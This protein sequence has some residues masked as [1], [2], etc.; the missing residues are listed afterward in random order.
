MMTA[1]DALG[2]S[3]VIDYQKSHWTSNVERYF[4]E[5]ST[6]S[7]QWYGKLADHFGLH[8]TVDGTHFERLA[9]GQHPHTGEQ[10]VRHRQYKSKNPES[11]EHRAAW[12]IQFAPPKSVS[13]TAL[14]AGD[15]RVREAHRKA[16]LVAL[17]AVEEYVQ[18]WCHGSVRKTTGNMVAALF[19]HDTSRPVNGYPAPQLHTHVVMMNMTQDVAEGKIRALETWELFRVQSYGTAIYRAELV[20]ELQKLGYKIERTKDGAFE[21]CGYTKEYLEAAS[22]R[23]QLVKATKEALGLTNSARAGKIIALATREAKVEMAP[24]V[25]RSLVRAQASEFGGQPDQVKSLAEMEQ[26]SY[27]SP[28]EERRNDLAHYG[29]THAKKRTLERIAVFD[30]YEILRDSLILNLGKTTLAD[31]RKAFAERL[32]APQQEFTEVFHHRQTAPG[33]RYT[34]PETERMEAEVLERIRTG[35]D[36]VMPV[37][38]EVSLKDHPDLQDNKK[39]QTVLER[40]LMTTDQFVA[41]QGSAGTKKSSSLIILKPYIENAGYEMVAYAPTGGATNELAVRGITSDTLQMLLATTQSTGIDP[42]TKPRYYIIDETSLADTEQVHQFMKLVRPGV[43]HVLFMGDDSFKRKVGQHKSVGAGRIFREMQEGGIKT[44]ELNKMYRQKTTVMQYVAAHTRDGK[45]E[46]ALKIMDRHGM[47]QEYANPDERFRAIAADF[48]SSPDR[49]FIA[50]ADNEVR[51]I[52]NLYTRE[53]QR[54]AGHLHAKDQYTGEILVQ[55]DTRKED[56]LHASYYTVGDVLRYPKRNKTVG[57]EPRDYADVVA[58]DRD[59]KTITVKRRSDGQTVTYEPRLAQGVQVYSKEQRSFAVGERIQFTDPIKDQNHRIANRD[60]GT[61]LKLDKHGN[62]RVRM[63]KDGGCRK[64]NFRK[65]QHLEYSYCMTSYALQGK[66]LA[67]LLFHVD[68]D[69]TRCRKLLG[70]D[71]TYTCATRGEVLFRIYCNLKDELPHVL[72]RECVKP[73]ALSPERVRSYRQEHEL[74]MTA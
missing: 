52:L 64:V 8:G 24:E 73:V 29:I 44:A 25:F 61:I 65:T 21:I 37:C 11:V 13:V 63:D 68:T 45:I 34:T 7:G 10:L 3:Q 28:S 36:S 12:D 66:T 54:E 20:F 62:A 33:H 32:A 27:I 57:V 60:T 69:D 41:V 38:R 59:A 55:R 26:R 1:S 48:A 39:R 58:V 22:P 70:A 72:S 47:I 43:D 5:E 74:S 2:A 40:I 19:E 16:T 35:R 15:D 46:D 71:M 31:S 23:H 50:N 30:E 56:T 4:S 49:T 9:Y 53:A 17:G 6:M 14:V 51:Q 18:A 67:R 42:T